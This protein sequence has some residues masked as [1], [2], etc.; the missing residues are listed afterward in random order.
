MSSEYITGCLGENNKS[1]N[2]DF[3]SIQRIKRNSISR[4][5]LTLKRVPHSCSNGETF[6][7]GIYQGVLSQIVV[8]W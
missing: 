2:V 4:V 7:I 6:I 3:C 8:G 5:D 1:V